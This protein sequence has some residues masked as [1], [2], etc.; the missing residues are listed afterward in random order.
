MALTIDEL[1]SVPTEDQIFD[2]WIANLET[3]GIGASS[4]KQG[5][6]ARTIL[7]VV[8]KTYAFFATLMQSAIK[9]MFLETSTQ[10]WLT[11][12]AFYVYGVSR[13]EAT[14]ATGTLTLSNGGGGVFSQAAG[15]VRFL[16]SVTGKA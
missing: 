8:A 15:T 11:L 9:S 7:R 2:S 5:G 13:I 6:T 12:L 1:L 16:S 10:G 4:W 3:L 14:F